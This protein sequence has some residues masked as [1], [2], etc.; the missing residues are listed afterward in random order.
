MTGTLHGLGLGPG[1]PELITVKSWRILSMAEVV[2]WPQAPSGAHR[3]RDVAAPFIPEDVIE[4]PL[5][6]PFGAAR[7]ALDAAY[8]AAAAAVSAH[9]RAGRDVAFICLGDPLFH[10]SFI[11]LM[12]RLQGRFP[13]QAVPGV[14]APMACAAALGRRLAAGRDILKILPGTAPPERLRAEIAAGP[15]AMAFIKAGRNLAAIRALLEEA[16]LAQDAFLVED[17]TGA[18]QKLTPLGEA[19]AEAPYF[20]TIMVFPPQ[21]AQGS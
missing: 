7:E 13:V 21:E 10:G 19:G 3:A 18:E 17:V 5:D 12:E 11:H 15:A 2:A 16:G 14:A 4:L 20:S 6:I 1:D 8:E 9:L